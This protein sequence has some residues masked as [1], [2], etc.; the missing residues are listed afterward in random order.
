MYVQSENANLPV[1]AAVV[2]ELDR[3]VFVYE[4]TRYFGRLTLDTTPLERLGLEPLSKEFTPIT[5]VARLSKSSQPIK[6]KLL[7]QSVIAGLGNIYASETLFRAGIRPTLPAKK[8]TLKQ[9]GRLNSAIRYVL[10]TAISRG[11]SIPLNFGGEGKTDGL[12]YFGSASDK[13]SPKR[14][15]ERFLVYDRVGKAC[16]KCGSKIRRTIQAAR[17]TFHCPKCQ[18]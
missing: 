16:V 3:H 7:D 8:L 2:L 14:K 15:G 4:D 13:D 18:K 11:S 1:H 9:A 10:K 12:F 6:V 17:S 5:L